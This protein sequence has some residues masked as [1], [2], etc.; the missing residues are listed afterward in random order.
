M[1]ASADGTR[2]STSVAS[3]RLQGSTWT[4]SPSW[5]ASVSNASRRVPEM[6][7]VAPCRCSAC[8]IAPPMPPLAPVTSAVLPVRSNIIL[9]PNSGCPHRGERVFRRTDIAGPANRNAD[10]ALGDT[11][12]QSAQHLAGSDFEKPY[13]P[14]MGHIS[15]RFAPAHGARDLLDQPSADLG[16]FGDRRSQYVRHQGC[17]RGLDG[18]TG[19]CLRHRV[20]RRL[21]QPAMKRRGDRKHHRAL[22]ALRFGDFDGP[23]DG[24]LVTGN[25]N[26]TAAIVVGG[27]A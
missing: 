19:Q 1:A 25:H 20:G 14:M 15:H 18:N 2:A 23:F 8:A 12:D 26:L 4:R 7:T 27:L 9:S 3:E 6:A 13:D 21:H 22:G 10:G 11:L 17:C 16:G 24:G 5:A